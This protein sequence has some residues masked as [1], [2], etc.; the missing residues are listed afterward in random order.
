MKSGKAL[1]RA[2]LKGF[3]LPLVVDGNKETKGRI[4]VIAGSREVAGAALLTATAAMRAGAGKLRMLCVEQVAVPTALAMP[5][6]MV[7]GLEEAKDGGFARSAVKK[8]R[9][10]AD[11]VDVVVAG[12][13]MAQARTCV[14][15]AQTLLE[16]SA[17]IVLDAALLHGLKPRSAGEIGSNQPPV[18]LPHSGELASLLDC[19]EKE[20]DLDPIGCGLR[21]AERH[22]AHVVVKGVTSHVV[23]ADGRAW[24]FRGGTPGLGVSGSGDTLAGIVGGLLARGASSLTALLWGVL[25][26]GEAGE[27]LA[28]KVGPTGFL[29]REIPDQIP[30]LLSR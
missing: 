28:T 5:E 15:L 2:A 19:D 1:T 14:A 11:R 23:A 18:L 4:L 10:E 20:I 22:R 7:I 30:A 8:I 3:P 13:G 16:S 9:D 24:T 6:A 21:A 27:R 17:S 12:P 29:A 25:L 26:H